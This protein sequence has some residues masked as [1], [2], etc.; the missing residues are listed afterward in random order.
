MGEFQ[1]NRGPGLHVLTTMNG[2]RYLHGDAEGE[3]DLLDAPPQSHQL[4]AR[5]KKCDGFSQGA[6]VDGLAGP[7]CQRTFY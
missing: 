6:E 5:V 7:T 4:P 2:K 3:V 1:S